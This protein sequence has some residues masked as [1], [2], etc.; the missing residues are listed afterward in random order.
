MKRKKIN[1]SEK[2]RP[3]F[4]IVSEEDGIKYFKCKE[5]ERLVNGT[6]GSNLT[7]HLRS[8][9]EIYTEVIRENPSIE[10]K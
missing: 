1:K 9:S 4:D 8:H 3:Y 7:S 2:S 10:K 5:C 6:K